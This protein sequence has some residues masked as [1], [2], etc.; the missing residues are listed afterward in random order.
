M[1]GLGLLGH[2]QGG[3]PG[4]LLLIAIENAQS[5]SADSPRDKQYLHLKLIVCR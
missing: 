5:S 3:Q 1:S 2:D 4:A